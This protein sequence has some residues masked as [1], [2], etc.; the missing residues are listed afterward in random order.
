MH[1]PE[2]HDKC[3]EIFRC[4]KAANSTVKNLYNLAE[5]FNSQ[6][7]IPQMHYALNIAI[8]QSDLCM[9]RTMDRRRLDGYTITARVS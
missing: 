9:L 7:S 3:M 4:S 8:E 2:S 1:S 5:T 6:V